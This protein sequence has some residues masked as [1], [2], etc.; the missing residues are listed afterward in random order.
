MEPTRAALILTST[1]TCFIDLRLVR[2]YL[3]CCSAR[4]VPSKVAS[5]AEGSCSTVDSV[6][7]GETEGHLWRRH[8]PVT[9][10]ALVCRHSADQASA[11]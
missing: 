7:D 10:H 4:K 2:V 8:R 1:R 3:S 9:V 11:S 6:L 5:V